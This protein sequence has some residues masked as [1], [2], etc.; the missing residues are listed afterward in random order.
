MIVPLISIS[1]A[2]STWL[3]LSHLCF[4]GA[5]MISDDEDVSML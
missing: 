5:L 3:M 4:V 2:V 1:A